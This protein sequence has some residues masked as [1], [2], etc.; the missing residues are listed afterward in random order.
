[1]RHSH[2]QGESADIGFRVKTCVE[3]LLWAVIVPVLA[4]AGASPLHAQGSIPTYPYCAQYSDGASLDCSFSTLSMCYQSVTGLG[5]V[6]IDNPRASSV[7]LGNPQRPFGLPYA[8]AP[9]PVPPP[10]AQQ[11]SAQQ[12]QSRPQLPSALPQQAPTPPSTSVVPQPPCNPLYS[13]TYC[14]SASS[15]SFASISSLSSDLAGAAPSPTTLGSSTF[16]G[17]TDCIGI[18][19]PFSCGG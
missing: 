17:D 10:P 19:R 7:A 6:C 9:S 1:L 3:I 5:G 18:L 11:L 15:N 13:G 16:S 12:T 2:L 4:D 14:A 8:F